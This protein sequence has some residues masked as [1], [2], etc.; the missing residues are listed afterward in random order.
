MSAKQTQDNQGKQSTPTLAKAV[1][2]H[3][4]GKRPEA[5]KE[6]NGAI[7]NGDQSAEVFAAKGHIQFE[8]EQYDDAVRTYEKLLAR[9]PGV[10]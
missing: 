6:L 2:L 4:E 5:L 3:L 9:N 7:E 10:N 1:S 8:L